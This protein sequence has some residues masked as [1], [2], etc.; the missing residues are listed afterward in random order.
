MSTSP[1]AT[2]LSQSPPEYYV[3][4]FPG[5]PVRIHFKLSVVASIRK[6]LFNG[7][8]PDLSK[9]AEAGGLL[10]GNSSPGRVEITDFQP[11][12]DP[13]QSRFFVLCDAGK[14]LLKNALEERRGSAGSTSVVGYFRSQVRD[15][16]RLCDEDLALIADFF[17]DPSHVF[18]L[19]RPDET[20]APLAGFFFRDGDSIFADSSL[21]PFPLDER[22]LA[23]IRPTRRS[24]EMPTQ[25]AEPLD[26]QEPLR[27][28]SARGWN[29]L[30]IGLP[31]I[32]LATGLG[33]YFFRAALF[34]KSSSAASPPAVS[35][36]LAVS[37][38]MSLSASRLDANVVITWDSQSP[39]ISNARVGILTIKDGDARKDLFLTNAQLQM[40]KVVYTPVT[41]RL[42]IALEVFSVDGKA[43]SDSVLY[44][45]STLPAASRGTTG[46]TI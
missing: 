25:A 2:E 5:A 15:G 33:V 11:F 29:L 35:F 39:V 3:W 23:I 20:G 45:L 36:P 4:T 32:A 40:R 13:G 17:P 34:H 16:L 8:D 21:M 1:P 27:L 26:G 14:S 38:P 46:G 37:S 44:I 30:S 12:E 9:C 31:M 22:L 24:I 42:E 6:Y 43:T 19:V 41:H 28:S 7:L 10:L 18:L